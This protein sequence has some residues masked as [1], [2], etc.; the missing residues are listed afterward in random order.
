MKEAILDVTG[1]LLI[2]AVA[3]MLS[4]LLLLVAIAAG[5]QTIK[6]LYDAAQ[7]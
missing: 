3:L 2:L 5:Y 4:P 1:S 6:E 7:A